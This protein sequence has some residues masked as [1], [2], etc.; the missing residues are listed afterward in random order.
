MHHGSGTTHP[1]RGLWW[2]IGMKCSSVWKTSE[3]LVPRSLVRQCNEVKSVDLHLFA[4]AS[5]LACSAATIALVKQ[6]TGTVPGLLAPKTRISKRNTT[7]FR[8]ELVAGHMAAN[9]AN[10]VQ[11]ALTRWPVGSIT[12]WMDSTVARYWL[13]IPG[14]SWK[15]FVANRVR[16]I[17]TE[18]EKLNISWKYCPTYKDIA[19]LGERWR[20][21]IGS[22]DPSGYSTKKNGENNQH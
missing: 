2:E 11:Q 21:V 14:N 15:V 20:K 3:S 17:A 22:L 13:M 4:D 12:I 18:T 6:D 5:N 16:R 10:N 9:M 7:M 19:N 1:Q 8:L